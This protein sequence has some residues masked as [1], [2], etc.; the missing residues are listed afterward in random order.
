[1]LSPVLKL[2]WNAEI[3]L[4]FFFFLLLWWR[5]IRGYWVGSILSRFSQHCSWFLLLING[6]STDVGST[7]ILEVISLDFLS[8]NTAL[9]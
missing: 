8:S 5:E 9:A 4:F 2:F 7:N 6:Q 1:M 3:N